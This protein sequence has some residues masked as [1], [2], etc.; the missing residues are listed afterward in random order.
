MPELSGFDFLDMLRAES[1]W[2]H[3][4]FAIHSAF[5]AEFSMGTLGNKWALLDGFFSRPLMP[6]VLLLEIRRML[7]L[8]FTARTAR[9]DQR[10]VVIAHALDNAFAD[11]LR[12]V[13]YPAG[14]I[15]QILPS[16]RRIQ[17]DMTDCD[18]G[19]IIL[20]ATDDDML[21]LL[22]DTQIGSRFPVVVITMS[23]PENWQ[24]FFAAGAREV[25]CPPIAD[26]VSAIQNAQYRHLL[27]KGAAHYA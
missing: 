26:L 20:Y 17:D 2:N 10:V 22:Q 5:P 23:S 1:V 12:A 3:I 7:A 8:P 11:A 25:C 15:F 6:H 14:F 16:L 9:R 18:P 13:L 24:K 4:P 27:A 21:S 19:C